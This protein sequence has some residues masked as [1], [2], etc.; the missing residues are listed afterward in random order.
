MNFINAQSTLISN[1]TCIENSSNRR[2][3]SWLIFILK[4]KYQMY[5]PKPFQLI[6]FDIF[7]PFLVFKMSLRWENII[8]INDCSHIFH[9][10]WECWTWVFNSIEY[11][12]VKSTR[13]TLYALSYYSHHLS[14]RFLI[15]YSLLVFCMFKVCF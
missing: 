5:S 10:E 7:V 2:K 14:T 11:S 12:I 4:I 8:M 6:K 15:W 13:F 1:S 3:L 9:N